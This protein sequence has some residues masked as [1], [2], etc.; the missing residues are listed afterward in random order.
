MRTERTSGASKRLLGGTAL[1]SGL[2]LAS[3]GPVLAQLGPAVGPGGKLDITVGGFAKFYWVV[4]DVANRFGGRQSSSDFRNDTEVHVKIQGKDAATGIVYGA[5]VEFEADTNRT[6]NT[7]E[8]YVFLRGAFGD[9]QFGDDDGIAK[10]FAIGA[11]KVAVATGGL[12]GEAGIDN[13][14]TIYLRAPN[15]DAT[16][17]KYKSPTLAGFQLGAS[18]TPSP[19]SEGDNLAVTNADGLEDVIEGALQWSGTFGEIGLQAS[20]VG[21]YAREDSGNDTYKGF[22]VGGKLSAFGFAIAGGW[23][24]ED[25]PLTGDRDFAN[26]GA[27]A[28]VGPVG[29]SVNY[30][31]AYDTDGAEPRA[32]ILGADVGVFPGLALGLEVS[33]FDQKR[34]GDRDDDGV[35]GLTSLRLA[36]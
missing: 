10:D 9:V 17:I 5:V 7:D 19:A 27:S 6:L 3:G 23:G 26:I 30:G 20:V 18:Y 15:N 4:G 32:L 21:A 25:S 35:L 14:D 12:D 2:L 13:A 28:S 36:F 33:F 1:A 29:I 34:P 11:H 16:K 31:N 24:T 22:Y 8:T